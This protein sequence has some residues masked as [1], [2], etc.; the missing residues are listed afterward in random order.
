MEHRTTSPTCFA[1]VV[2]DGMPTRSNEQHGKPAR[3]VV[4]EAGPT[5]AEGGWSER[6]TEGLTVPRKPGNAGGGKECNKI[7]TFLMQTLKGF[8][9]T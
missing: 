9:T 4:Q 6:V 1:G 8:M 2:G 7:L 5:D 3:V